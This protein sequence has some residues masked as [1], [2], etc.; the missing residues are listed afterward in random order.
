MPVP[1]SHAAD[2]KH[3]DPTTVTC[4]L[5]TATVRSVR[6][7]VRHLL[8]DRHGVLV[9]DAVLVA[10]E[11]VSNAYR[12]G[13]PPRTCRLS[14]ADQDRLRVEV[15]DAEAAHPRIRTPDTSGG[16]GLVL[17]DRLSTAWG[18]LP[19]Q[20][21]KTVWADLDLAQRGNGRASHLAL[22]TAEPGRGDSPD[23]APVTCADMD[24]R[25]AA[26]ST[27]E[28]V[29]SH[30]T[31]DGVLVVDAVG[32]VDLDTAPEL[33]RAI[34]D[35]VERTAGSG[36]VLDLTHVTFLDSAGLRALITAT[37]YAEQRQQPLRIVVDANRP[38]I[39]PIEVTGLDNWLR[40][41]HSVAEAVGIEQQSS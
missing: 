32:D 35:A 20:D 4:D 33:E 21:Q 30:R 25:P 9:E 26:E 28:L 41:Y 16:R 14:L 12:H 39:R 37:R 15:G 10:E 5:D 1:L 2:G 38:V 18:V 27:S 23:R 40:L 34:I 8:G 22:A 6:E 19:G 29:I 17:V 13:A 36:C 31:V 11:L 7:L 24:Q 3:D